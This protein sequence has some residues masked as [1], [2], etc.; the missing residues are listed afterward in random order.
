MQYEPRLCHVPKFHCKP[1][2]PWSSRTLRMPSRVARISRLAAARICFCLLTTSGCP[3][4]HR[5]SRLVLT[6]ITP[7]PSLLVLQCRRRKSL[8]VFSVMFIYLH[9]S[10][11]LSRVPSPCRHSRVWPPYRCHS[12]SH[13]LLTPASRAFLEPIEYPSFL[14]ISRQSGRKLEFSFRLRV[15]QS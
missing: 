6:S 14:R 11:P 13:L 4:P 5:K 8:L 15:V 3:F 2:H 12:R 10:R 1:N 9:V 7:R